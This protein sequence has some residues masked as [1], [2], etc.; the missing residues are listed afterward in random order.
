[1]VSGD[2]FV[3][4]KGQNHYTIVLLDTKVSGNTIV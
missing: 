4:T 3:S 2:T 1:M